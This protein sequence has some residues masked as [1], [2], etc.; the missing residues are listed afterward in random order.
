MRGLLSRHD[1]NWMM[2]VLDEITEQEGSWDKAAAL[3]GLPFQNASQVLEFKLRTYLLLYFA[4]GLSSFEEGWEADPV[5]YEI[6]RAVALEFR[7]E[8]EALSVEFGLTF[9][10]EVLNSTEGRQLFGQG[11]ALVQKYNDLVELLLVGKKAENGSL[12]IFTSQLFVV[13]A[14]KIVLQYLFSQPF[15]VFNVKQTT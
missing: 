3:Y 6:M 4:Q 2:S 13:G 7:K 1:V 15:L 10:P 9:E 5:V 14:K 12:K 8:L 11:I